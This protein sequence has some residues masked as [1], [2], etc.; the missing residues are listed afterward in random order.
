MFSLPAWL[1]DFIIIFLGLVI[2]AIPFIL[3]G[4]ALSS[5]LSFVITD[6]QIL[7]WLPKNRFLALCYAT[8]TGFLLP[9]CECGNVPLARKFAIKGVPPYVAITFLLAAP[10][11]NPIV[12]FSTWAAFRDMPEVIVFRMVFAVI[13][14]FAVGLIFSFAHERREVLHENIVKV[15][16]ARNAQVDHQHGAHK[17]HHHHASSGKWSA[18]LQTIQVEFLEMTTLMIIGAL[19]AAATQTFVP[20]EWIVSLGTGPIISIVAMLIL[21]FVVSICSNVDAFFALAY[22]PTFT[23]GSIVAF[24]VFGPMIDL[25]SL[26]MMSTTF[27]WRTLAIISVLTVQIVFILSLILNLYVN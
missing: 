10:V 3:L 17:H 14:A 25:K 7:H 24:L 6:R 23:T 18:F 5:L 4:V 12:L 16:D 26:L 19:I 27:R 21:A 22:A 11:I 9:V 1:N 20:R 15:I 13:T 8:V 2:E